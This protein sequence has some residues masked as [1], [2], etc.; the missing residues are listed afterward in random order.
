MSTPGYPDWTQPVSQAEHDPVLLPSA[1]LASGA[2]SGPFNT[3]QIQSLSL[4]VAS[5]GASPAGVRATVSL[6]WGIGVT[7]LPVQTM[8]LNRI[9]D[10][11][12]IP[13]SLIWQIPVRGAAVS[14]SCETSDARSLTV[15]LVGSTRPIPSPLLS[16]DVATNQG[17]L[18]A[19]TVAAVAAGATETLYIQPVARAYALGVRG[20]V[21][22]NLIGYVLNGV[23]KTGG[24]LT[25]L[26]LWS[27]VGQ[28]AD[29]AVMQVIAPGIGCEL[30]ITNNDTV[31]RSPAL[32]V[33]DVS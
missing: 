8:S 3:S 24:A 22:G 9:P 11:Q 7:P 20:V 6:L 2:V 5:N 30:T 27:A 13:G 1:A 29:W 26:P 32:R 21:N 17:N 31:S 10:Y 33:W 4:I 12:T 16:G 23:G 15:G 25:G 18:L 14:V 19:T 28:T